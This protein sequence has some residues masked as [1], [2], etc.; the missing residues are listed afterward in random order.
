[1]KT[2]FKEKAETCGICFDEIEFQG[3]INSCSHLFCFKC[4]KKWSDNENSCPICKSRFEKITRIARRKEYKKSRSIIKLVR[5]KNQE[6]VISHSEFIMLLQAAS[7]LLTSELQNLL[8][9]SLSK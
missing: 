4:I 6:R 1:M 3:K 2:R 7:N 5:T 8:A 9:F